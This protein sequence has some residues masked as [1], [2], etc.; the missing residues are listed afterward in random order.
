MAL[1]SELTR[2]HLLVW[3]SVWI[4][5]EA[6]LCG[7][8]LRLESAPAGAEREWAAKQGMTGSVTQGQGF[9]H[10][11]YTRDKSRSADVLPGRIHLYLEGDGRPWETRYR[12]APDPTPRDPYSL[13]LMARDG[14][15]AIYVGRPCYHGFASDPGCEPWLWTQGRYSLPVVESMV[16][17]I[18]TVLP[19][20][21]RP[22]IT[23]IGYSGGGVLAV[24]IAARLE[25]VDEVISVAANLDIDAWAERLRYS[26]LDGSLNPA[27]QAPLDQSI[28]QLHLAGEDDRQVPPATLSAFLRRNPT[29]ELRIL[30]DFDHRCCWVEH[31]PAIAGAWRDRD[32]THPR[33]LGQWI[34]TETTLS[35][36]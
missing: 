17:A 4:L 7:C 9:R 3:V 6:A 25:G 26:P 23:L 30:E 36:L 32:A 5:A 19:S 1:R 14:A 11:I 10:L 13:R 20:S 22:R 35:E 21:S 34:R 12:V 8:A 15:H 29:A 28:R 2:C 24:L 33:S 31:W 18:E 27:T 16:A